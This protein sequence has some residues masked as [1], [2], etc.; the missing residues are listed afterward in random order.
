MGTK[1]LSVVAIIADIS[2]VIAWIDSPGPFFAAVTGALFVLTG[3]LLFLRLAND[4]PKLRT[5]ASLALIVVG[6]ITLTVLVDRGVFTGQPSG[7]PPDSGAESKVPTQVKGSPIPP[8]ESAAQS[9]S[10]A[11]T[12]P[13]SAWSV[14]V[15][16]SDKMYFETGSIR[17]DATDY[18]PRA[19]K[20]PATDRHRDSEYGG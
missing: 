10:A 17:V 2:A 7:S 8:T 13:V 14:P 12:G 1:I 5:S 6:V 11:P 9:S 4:L 3:V 19:T 15:A 20:I 18:V 16:G